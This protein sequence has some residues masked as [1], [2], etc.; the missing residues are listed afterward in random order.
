M[1][2]AASV[3]REANQHEFCKVLEME[4]Q[5]AGLSSLEITILGREREMMLFIGT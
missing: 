4:C 1:D 5:N 2:R 3:A